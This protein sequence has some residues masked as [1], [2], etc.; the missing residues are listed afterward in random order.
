RFNEV[1]LV[2]SKRFFT[3]FVVGLLLM[4]AF[5]KSI[6]AWVGE[7]GHT[8]T[9]C[10][11]TISSDIH[12]MENP[13]LADG[14]CHG[15]QVWGYY[16]PHLDDFALRGAADYNLKENRSGQQFVIGLPNVQGYS[17][18]ILTVYTIKVEPPKQEDPPKQEEPPKKENPTNP[19]EQE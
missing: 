19:P 18:A 9:I 8:Y 3:V 10:T 7:D 17:S 16:M 6:F 4:L 15:D 14:V 11:L 2:L 5:P 12:T 13:A 1:S